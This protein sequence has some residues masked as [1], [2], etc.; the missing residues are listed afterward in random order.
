MSEDRY[1]WN[2]IFK[3]KEKGCPICGKE[4][5]R[6]VSHVVLAEERW[7][8]VNHLL[9]EYFPNR[10][11]IVEKSSEDKDEPI[12]HVYQTSKGE[13]LTYEEWEDRKK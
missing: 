3:P 6:F 4:I 1:D 11:I 10:Y 8:H 12:R 13:F 7:K 5:C 2:R 9:E